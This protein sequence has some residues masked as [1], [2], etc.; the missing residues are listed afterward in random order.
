MTLNEW[1]VKGRVGISSKTMWAVLQG[2]EYTGDK[3]Y[4]PD[5]F[6]RCY[7]FVKQCNITEQDLKKISITLPYWEPYIENWQKLTEMYEQNV[8]ENW[9]NSKKVGM[10]EFMQ[11]LRA[12]SDLIGRK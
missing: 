10:C 2:I 7:E 12:K 11:E 9:V 4:D 8:K 6:S 1:I 5:D 3:P